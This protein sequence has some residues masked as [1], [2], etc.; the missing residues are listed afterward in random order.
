MSWYGIGARWRLQSVLD[1]TRRSVPVICSVFLA[2][3]LASAGHDHE[4]H[5]FDFEVG[6][7]WSHG[8][9]TPGSPFG[10]NYL[11]DFAPGE[12]VRLGI[13]DALPTGGPEPSFGARWVILSFDLVNYDPSFE[14]FTLTTQ[15]DNI[16]DIE[17]D[18]TLVG[19]VPNLSVETIFRYPGGD[20]DLLI[21]FSKTS[22]SG[23]WGLDNVVV[24]WNIHNVP[25]PSA[26]ILILLFLIGPSALRRRQWN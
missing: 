7:G 25:E 26:T 11:G 14:E 17:T 12:S 9:S 6:G 18:A 23:Q 1:V 4:E 2:P 13:M 19:E 20:N 16:I 5:A 15:L 3:A 24:D 8:T 21:D 10:E 22:G